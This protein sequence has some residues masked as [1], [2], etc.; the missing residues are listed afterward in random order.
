MKITIKELRQIIREVAS[1]IYKKYSNRIDLSSGQYRFDP[2]TCTSNKIYQAV[3]ELFQS[4]GHDLELETKDPSDQA[5]VDYCGDLL[6]SQFPLHI[7]DQIT[8]RLEKRQ[9]GR[10]DFIPPLNLENK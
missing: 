8:Q 10:N 4:V 2:A 5:F 7:V 9:F 1:P 3:M 6:S